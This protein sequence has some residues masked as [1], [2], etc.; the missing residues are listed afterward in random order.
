MGDDGD[1]DEGG[2]G[3]VWEREIEGD[4]RR[5]EDGPMK[6]IREELISEW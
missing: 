2:E 3:W 6:R 1:D 4:E 5:E